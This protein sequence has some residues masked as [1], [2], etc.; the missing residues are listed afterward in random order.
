VHRIARVTLEPT[1]R[2]VSI[3]GQPLELTTIEYEILARLVQHAGTVI[4]R[5]QLIKEV[6]E[7]QPFIE[8]RALDVHIS[9]L[10][11]KLGHHASL[12]VTIRGVGHMLRTSGAIMVAVLILALIALT[13]TPAAAQEDVEP[14]T[15]G[16]RGVT[17][18]G[19]AGFLDKVSS[20]EDTF[21]TRLTLHVDVNRFVTGRI[22]VR[23]GVIGSTTFGDD[24]EA[25]TGPGAAAL[26][27]IGGVF[28]YF[29][30]QSI[31]SAYAGAEYRAQLTHRADRDS[32]TV[33]GMGGVQAML[34]SRASVFVQGGLGRRLTR[35]D[36]GELQTR[37]A[38][39]IG[40]R[41]KF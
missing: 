13:A 16:R 11:K 20:S 12:I 25:V 1:A 7:R 40:L 8:D 33:L 27:A 22:A 23:G 30:P 39:E 32:G 17:S 35:G 4:S 2:S 37:I 3:D 15:V 31:L 41:F 5:E 24:D 36:E 34:S 19:V 6:F 14:R 18:V 29:T 9:H 21:P 10:R 38:G 26:H 28:Y